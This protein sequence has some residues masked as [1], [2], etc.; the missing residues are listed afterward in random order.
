MKHHSAHTVGRRIDQVADGLRLYKVELTVENGSSGELTRLGLA[1][2]RLEEH[3]HDS[4]WHSVPAVSR[5]LDGVFA[6]IRSRPM[7]HRDG[8]LIDQRS[9]ARVVNATEG[10]DTR[11][12]RPGTDNPRGNRERG[13]A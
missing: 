6:G 5:K 12:E 10:G 3:P 7:K 2:A 9:I 11:F 8:G 4:F 1:S 13:R